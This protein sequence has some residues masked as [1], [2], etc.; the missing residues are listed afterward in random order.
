[1]SGPMPIGMEEY[2]QGG[3]K[4]AYFSPYAFNGG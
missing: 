4:Q 3:P 2:L 1:M